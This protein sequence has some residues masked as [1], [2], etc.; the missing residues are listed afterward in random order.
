MCMGGN[1]DT[2]EKMLE[3]H[4]AASFQSNDTPT[5]PQ[6]MS[7]IERVRAE[8]DALYEE[9]PSWVEGTLSR[10]KVHC[11]MAPRFKRKHGQ[12]QYNRRK[13]NSDVRSV[14]HHVIRIAPG[15]MDDE[16]DWQ[17]TVR[18]EVAHAL[19]YEKW[20][21]SQRHNSNWKWVCE[22]VG[23]EPTRCADKR[24]TER[25]YKFACS[26]GCWETGK[27]KRSKKIK[28]PWS[29]YCNDCGEMCV[30]WDAGNPKPTEP[31]VC[32]VASIS[33]RTK[34]EYYE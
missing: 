16:H 34:D 1:N 4:A 24:H 17:D 19:A 32:E 22:E 30:S 23:A 10:E 5:P 29:R 28:R 12:C 13:A 26:N 31:G 9:A 18:H 11:F 33:W 27:L 25:P 15:I 6:R 21:S 2:I 14:G 20:G 7:D 3:N 8:V